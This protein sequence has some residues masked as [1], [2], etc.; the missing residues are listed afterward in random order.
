MY[1][2]IT[3]GPEVLPYEVALPLTINTGQVDGTLAFDVPDHLRN[4]VFRRDR[5][6]HVNMVGHQ[7]PLLDSA[8]LLHCQSTEDFPEMLPQ[9]AIQRL[10]AALGNE[11]HMVFAVPFAVA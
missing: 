3:A 4:R 5:Y 9:L 6:H 10:S 1:S 11:H 8:L 2:L 7:M